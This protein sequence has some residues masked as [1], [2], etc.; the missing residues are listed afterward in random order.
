MFPSSDL[1]EA[2]RGAILARGQEGLPLLLEQLRSPDK[3]FFQLALG[4]FRELPGGEIDKVFAKEL[5]Q[6]PPERAALL[7]Y[8]MADRPE[9]V[10][11]PAITTAAA[12]G[13]KPVRLA[14]GQSSGRVGD[15]SSLATLLKAALDKDAELSQTARESLA[16]SQGRED[17]RRNCRDA[18]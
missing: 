4:T 5:E 8:A 3:G 13:A 14:A 11:V 16:E 2:T 7:I 15:A 9:T 6:A 18:A 12:N 10:S 1:I 17:R